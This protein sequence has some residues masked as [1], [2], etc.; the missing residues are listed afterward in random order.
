MDLST[1]AVSK[2]SSQTQI[3]IVKKQLAYDDGV[4][5]R[6]K[7]VGYTTEADQKDIVRKLNYTTSERIGDFLKGHNENR[8]F[9]PLAAVSTGAFCGG[10]GAALAGL[11][12]GAA[13]AAFGFLAGAGFSINNNFFTQ[14]ESE[15]FFPEKETLLKDTAKKYYEYL[16]NNNNKDGKDYT[17][18]L[19]ELKRILDEDN[20]DSTNA[21]ILDRIVGETI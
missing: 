20:I 12:G 16:Q 10:A 21:K 6:F 5:V 8:A 19:L 17:K 7:L 11:P 4:D 13:G 3:A 1:N 14:L 15:Y 9:S 18:Q 2:V